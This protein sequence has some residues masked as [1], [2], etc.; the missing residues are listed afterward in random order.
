MDN[1]KRLY[2]AG[3]IFLLLI[4]CCFVD[5]KN[6]VSESQ[7]NSKQSVSKGSLYLTVN[8]DGVRS[9]RR[10]LRPQTGSIVH[11]THSYAKLKDF[12]IPEFTL[13]GTTFKQALYQLR[14]QYY[15]ICKQ[16]GETPI[17][18]Q[19]VLDGASQR[20][21]K[22]SM[23]YTS[24][25]SMLKTLAAIEGMNMQITGRTI[26]FTRIEKAGTQDSIDIPDSFDF[27]VPREWG[28]FFDVELP[29]LAATF[30]IPIDQLEVS[31]ADKLSITADASDIKRI[32]SLF[33]N[34]FDRPSVQFRTSGRVINVSGDSDFDPQWL[35]DPKLTKLMALKGTDIMTL[36]S[37]MARNDESAIIEV[38]KE[39]I[40][41]NDSG[42][43]NQ[44]NIGITL[45]HQ[46]GQLGFGIGLN[47][48]FLE[49]YLTGNKNEPVK[50]VDTEQQGYSQLSKPVVTKLNTKDGSLSYLVTT[51]EEID[52]SG[53]IS[54]RSP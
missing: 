32:E 38:I 27:K 10:S 39:Y 52:P 16:T 18:F 51:Y 43:F 34:Y 42:G 36:P 48:E 46:T 45:T 9:S 13:D 30:G 29:W 22:F 50:Y 40:Y 47:T 2:L 12:I 5:W 28:S 11:A 25:T 49:G 37:V 6:P 53:K 31:V 26:S 24:F 7:E 19:F 15:E 14:Q 44:D 54:S 35:S 33:K 4:L 1:K 21:I 20:E 3:T 17:H 8:D 23:K 41:P